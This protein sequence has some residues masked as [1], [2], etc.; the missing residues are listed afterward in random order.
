MGYRTPGWLYSGPPGR[1]FSSLQQQKQS[2]YG[3]EYSEYYSVVAIKK[4]GQSWGWVWDWIWDC[5]ACQG[6]TTFPTILLCLTQG[7]RLPRDDRLERLGGTHSS[8]ILLLQGLQSPLGHT[9][10]NLLLK[11]VRPDSSWP[12][13]LKY[14]RTCPQSLCLSLLVRPRYLRR[15]RR[16][17]RARTHASA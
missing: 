4:S 7:P 5:G 12:M 14:G 9:T 16:A 15:A 11:D 2:T 3:V 17:S 8:D 13:N 1:G 6:T 10:H